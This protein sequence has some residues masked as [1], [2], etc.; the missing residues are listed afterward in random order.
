[1]TRVTVAGVPHW[2][3]VQQLLGRRDW[4]Q[5]EDGWTTELSRDDAADLMA[6]LRG[7][8]LGGTVLSVRCQPR[9]KRPAVRAGRLRDARARRQTTP[10][11]DRPGCRLD[12]EGKWSLTPSVLALQL[13]RPWSGA[14]VV[15][16]TCG[17]GGNAIG[18]ARAGCEVTAI[19][20]DAGRLALARHNAAEYGVS[21]RIRF[22]HG[23]ALHEA[24]ARQADLLFA[25]PPWGTD[26]DRS[27]TRLDELPLVQEL[28]D[29]GYP[30]TVLKVPPSF[31]PTTVP[32]CT[33]RAWFGTA[34]G[35]RHRV[36]FVTVSVGR[37]PRPPAPSRG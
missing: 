25:D 19:D 36:K 32:D 2:I 10:G 4:A 33:P 21:D 5:S 7:V 34:A 27:R 9:L 11:F 18:F 6:R 14:T 35:D 12:A 22:V 28:L 15:D 13:A 37:G 8:G 3:G 24:A 26:W 17:A 31:D 16:A 1:M 23:D 30:T 20:R 29:L